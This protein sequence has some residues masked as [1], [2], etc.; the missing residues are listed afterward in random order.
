V[1]SWAGACAGFRSLCPIRD[2]GSSVA[3]L[4]RGRLALSSVRCTQKGAEGH[5]H[6]LHS[7]TKTHRFARTRHPPP[8]TS[9]LLP[10]PLPAALPDHTPVLSGVYPPRGTTGTLLNLQ[11]TLGAGE[12]GALGL[13]TVHVGGFVCSLVDATGNYLSTSVAPALPLLSSSPV[14]CVVPSIEAGVYNISVITRDRGAAMLSQSGSVAWSDTTLL[15]HHYEQVAVV[16]AITPPVVS[17]GGGS[18]LIV[19]GSGF[20]GESSDVSVALGGFPCPVTFAS[21]GEIQCAVPDIGSLALDSICPVRD[22][23]VA[24]FFPGAGIGSLI[25]GS[26]GVRLQT[27]LDSG[28]LVNQSSE[29][30]PQFIPMQRYAGVCMMLLG[31]PTLTTHEVAT[32]SSPPHT[33]K[34][35]AA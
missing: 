29:E 26:R 14:T 18:T 28:P 5:D 21:S 20:S 34:V 3:P 2:C 9:T 22:D 31:Y 4:R 17:A 10:M 32:K 19:T 1:R 30:P 7:E 8:P 16:T 23:G 24:T 25:Q 13:L 15:L 11:G 35:F 6:R 12:H 33:F 27:W